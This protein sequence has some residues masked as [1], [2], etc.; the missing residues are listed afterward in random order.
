MIGG[1]L[2]GEGWQV[3]F[4]GMLFYLIFLLYRMLLAFIFPHE[5]SVLMKP[6][7]FK[8]LIDRFKTYPGDLVGVDIG[9]TAIKVAHVRKTGDEIS[10]LGVE[11]L[12]SQSLPALDSETSETEAPAMLAVEPLHLSPKTKGKYAA[13]AVT[14]TDAVV[15][16]LSFPGAFDDSAIDKIVSSLGL[17]DPDAYRIG[18]KL[19]AEGHGKSETKVLGVAVPEKVAAVA[20]Q[21]FP[22]GTPA[23]Y[24]LEVSGLAAMSS[25]QHSS[26][27]NHAEE[28]VGVADFG[29]DVT[30]YS[31]FNK[32]VL[33]LVRRFDFG[34][35]MVVDKV[36]EALGV[37]RETAQGIMNDG[38]FDIS[39]AVSE[40]MEPLVKQMIVSRDF[41]ERRENC[42]ISRMFIS[43]GIVASK[44]SLDEMR[45]ALGLEVESWDPFEGLTVA[46]DAIPDEVKGQEWRFVGALGACLGTLEEA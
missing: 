12:G 35:L 6:I 38:A 17:D 13:L 3:H 27:V 4:Y 24:S 1:V 32:G 29:T 23:P 37:D 28:S 7:N 34:T 36:Q 15:K 44:N 9:G 2:P 46:P 42:T 40:V 21:F 20:S 25:F 5:G 30:T 43:G 41:V 22:A 26:K 10:L 14:A 33:S 31:L 16:L 11:I 39:Q 18:Y 45:V 19:I 8:E